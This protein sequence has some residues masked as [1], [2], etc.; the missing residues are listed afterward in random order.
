MLGKRTR[1]GGVAAMAAATA[2]AVAAGPAEAAVEQR[3]AR[4]QARGNLGPIAIAVVTVGARIG[5]RFGPTIV[6]AIRGGS[7]AAKRGRA[8]MRKITRWGKRYARRGRRAAFAAWVA[9]RRLPKWIQGC[10]LSAVEARLQGA[11]IVGMAIGCIRGIL[12]VASG[13]D[14]STDPGAFMSKRLTGPA[15]A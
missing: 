15:Y 2:L 9:F 14:P 13:K 3:S 7:R 8:G 5:A 1:T 4:P 6:R 11:G 10:G 12:L